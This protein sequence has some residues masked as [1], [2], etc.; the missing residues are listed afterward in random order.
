MSEHLIKDVVRY[1]KK[2]FFAFT[3][4]KAKKEKFIKEKSKKT[5]RQWK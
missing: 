1:L 4:K 5:M 2:L 3:H